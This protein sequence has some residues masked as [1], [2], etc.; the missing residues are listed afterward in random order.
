M[1]T[2]GILKIYLIVGNIHIAR[3]YNRLAFVQLKKVGSEVI[4]PSASVLQSLKLGFGIRSIYADEVEVTKFKSNYS[5][6]VVMFFNTYSVAY[7]QRLD[8]AENRST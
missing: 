2:L 1:I 8:L 6:L 3:Y 7:V 5:S 4:L